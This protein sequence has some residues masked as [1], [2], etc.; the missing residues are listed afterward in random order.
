MRRVRPRAQ[1]T[2]RPLPARA[3][4]YARS[5]TEMA[6]QAQRGLHRLGGVRLSLTCYWHRYLQTKFL[7]VLSGLSEPAELSRRSTVFFCPAPLGLFPFDCAATLISF[8]FGAFS[9]ITIAQKIL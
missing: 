6:R 8:S 7:T 1:G 5:R 2:V 3:A 4:L 9:A